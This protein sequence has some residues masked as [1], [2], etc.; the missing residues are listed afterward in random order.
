MTSLWRDGRAPIPSDVLS[1]ERCDDVVV[2]AGITGLTTA[3]LLARAGRDVVVLEARDVGSVATG[4]TTAKVSLLQGTKYSTLLRRHPVDVAS[5]YLEANRAGQDW[6]LEYCQAQ[7]IAVQRRDA[8]T[9]APDT[10]RGR[11]AA[12]REHE[13]ATAVG[14]ATR[15]SDDLPVPFPHAGGVVLADQAQ[16]DPMELLHGLVADLRAAGGRV[17]T[18]A[19]VQHV[20]V[21]G[22]PTVRWDGGRVSSDT[23]VLATGAP[24]VDRA[25]HFARLEPQRSYALAFDHPDPPDLMLLSA[26][27]SSRSVRD[28]PGDGAARRLLVGGEGH[29]VGR[30]RHEQGHLDRLREWTA[31]HFPQAVETHHWSAQDYTSTDA[32]PRVGLLPLGRGRVHVATGFAKWGMTNGAAAALAVSGQILGDPVP[33]AQRLHRGRGRLPA[34][35]GMARINAGVAAAGSLELGRAALKPLPK[36]VPEGEGAVGR[37]GLLP[38]GR[39]TIDGRTCTVTAICT[40]LGGVLEWNDAD[41][42]YDCPLHGSRFAPT[43]EVLEGPATRALALRDDDHS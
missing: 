36:H 22:R 11:R 39:S 6:V 34:A 28:A 33:W 25:L 8:V 14:L 40:H 4:N 17:V 24:T 42:S 20:S 16:L 29:T 7:G 27:G 9:Y 32:L 30:A 2:G 23:I 19:R 15:W 37:E 18:G 26:H 41:Q 1:S 5:A 13:A 43:G 21:I 3:L 31:E 35:V 10:D 38:A 12:L